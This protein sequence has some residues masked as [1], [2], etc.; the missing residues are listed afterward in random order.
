MAVRCLFHKV[1][2]NETEFTNHSV[3]KL[4]SV[5]YG[6]SHTQNTG[7]LNPTNASLF[8][9]WQS[10]FKGVSKFPGIYAAVLQFHGL[11][12]DRSAARAHADSLYDSQAQTRQNSTETHQSPRHRSTSTIRLCMRQPSSKELIMQG[13]KKEAQY[14]TA[15]SDNFF[16]AVSIPLLI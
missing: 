2:I 11:P 15:F 3:G 16:Y 10:L 12:P 4:N 8:A 7:R 13:P 6:F 9:T 1:K 14:E 5:K